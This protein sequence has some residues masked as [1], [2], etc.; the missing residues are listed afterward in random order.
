MESFTFRFSK[1][2]H[3]PNYVRQR[4]PERRKKIIR[5]IE[6]KNL[7]N[8]SHWEKVP[9]RGEEKRIERGNAVTPLPFYLAR[10]A[11]TPE[12][13]NGRYTSDRRDSLRSD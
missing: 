4:C 7:K 6:R 11:R 10:E 9:G 3:P 2:K 12:P 1:E 5:K 8:S 13:T